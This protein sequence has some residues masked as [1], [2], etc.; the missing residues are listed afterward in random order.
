MNWYATYKD[1]ETQAAIPAGTA[2]ISVL[3]SFMESASR[4]IDDYCH[5]FFYSRIETLYHDGARG[6]HLLVPDL[7]SVTTMTADTDN[8]G[9]YTDETWTEGTDFFLENCGRITRFPKNLIRLTERGNY[10]FGISPRRYEIAGIWGFGDGSRAAP[11]DTVPANGTLS[12]GADTSLT[13]SADVSTEIYTGSTILMESEQIFVS[14]YTTGTTATVV[15]RMN[16]TTATGHTGVAISKAAY[17]R[18]IVQCCK[19]IVVECFFNRQGID[20]QYRVAAGDFVMPRNEETF[21]RT[22]RMI[23]DYRLMAVA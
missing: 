19:D 23:N 12:D 6:N 14:S 5:R 8:D 9:D 3:E 22:L 20:S 18:K 21:Y 17:P 13:L 11:W 7:L 10:C 16:G 1:I 2:S 4:F 15:R